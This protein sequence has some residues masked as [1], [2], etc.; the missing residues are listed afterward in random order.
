MVVLKSCIK[1][2][3]EETIVNTKILVCYLPQFH[4]ISENNEWWGE[5]FTEWTNVRK[6]TPLYS[7]HKQPK[8]PLNN[9]YYNLLNKDTVEWQT[10]L[11]NKYGIYGFCY[12]HYYFSILFV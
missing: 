4:E 3:I 1:E 8:V 11:A 10:A 9:N 6:T 12:F 5:G 2:W 7:W